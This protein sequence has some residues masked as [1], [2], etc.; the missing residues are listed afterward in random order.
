MT[1]ACTDRSINKCAMLIVFVNIIQLELS[2]RETITGF[3]Q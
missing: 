3:N 1:E 2:Q